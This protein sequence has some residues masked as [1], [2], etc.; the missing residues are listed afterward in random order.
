MDMHGSQVRASAQKGKRAK[1]PKEPKPS[2]KRTS[3]CVPGCACS[4]ILGALM[5]W[6]PFVQELPELLQ[7]GQSA[8]KKKKKQLAG[9]LLML[10][11]HGMRTRGHSYACLTG[12]QC[13]APT[14]LPV[15]TCQ[16]KALQSAQLRSA[17]PN[18]PC[19]GASAQGNVHA[20]SVDTHEMLSLQSCIRFSV[21]VCTAMQLGLVFKF[22]IFGPAG[23]LTVFCFGVACY[24]LY[25][26]KRPRSPPVAASQTDK[27]AGTADLAATAGSAAKAKAA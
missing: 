13:S 19:A 10:V 14:Q 20:C 7:L 9:L 8:L 4:L 1:T 27:A 2:C 5:A 3:V 18:A 25:S 21:P 11:S 15:D 23:A 22:G 24:S 16:G 6:S 12:P 26:P 17:V